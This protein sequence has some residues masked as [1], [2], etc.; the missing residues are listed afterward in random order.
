M[1]TDANNGAAV[2][3][4]PESPELPQTPDSLMSAGLFERFTAEA[5]PAD[6]R[7]LEDDDDTEDDRPGE[8][9]APEDGDGD[10]DEAP[11]GAAD[12]N[13]DEDSPPPAEDKRPKP[14]SAAEWYEVIAADGLQRMAE[15]PPKERAEVTRLHGERM[16]AQAAETTRAQLVAFIE[17]KDAAQRWTSEID[18]AFGG[19]AEA[20]AAWLEA[21]DPNS[22]DENQRNAAVYLNA[23]RWLR[24]FEQKT[25]AEQ[26]QAVVAL[27]ARANQQFTRLA[28]F[29]EAQA[30]LQNRQRANRYP[31]TEDGMARLQ[32]DVDE[33]L[34][35][36][37]ATRGREQEDGA[38]AGERRRPRPARVLLA[39]NV[40]AGSTR[41]R[42]GAVDISNNT[43]PLELAAIGIAQRMKP[44]R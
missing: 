24:S 3:P 5:P 16:A 29:P 35:S 25:P 14:R 4:A 27:N 6:D 38:P 11:D 1:T 42:T 31:A 33:L 43:D 36:S 17:Q 2:R 7:A 26:T 18:E 40:P 34:E 30:E 12:I 8:G 10:E 19:D 13:D 20:K 21:A 32:A 41:P 15:V 23:K 9:D 37:Y 44:K 39:D 28:K 22:P